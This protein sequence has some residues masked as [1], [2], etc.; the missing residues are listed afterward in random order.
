MPPGEL[1]GR[2]LREF[3]ADDDDTPQTWSG[4]AHGASTCQEVR[5]VGGD[6]AVRNAIV[7][8]RPIGPDDESGQGVL[9]GT[10]TAGGILLMVAD[11]TDLRKAE[12]A[13]REKESVLRS[14]Y[15]SSVMAMG[16]IEQTEDDTRFIS[17]N[18]LT[19]RFFGL[20]PGKLEGMTAS[21][22]RSTC[23]DD[24]GLDRAVP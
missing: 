1:V 24:V 4:V 15:E 6:G 20:A 14:F 17:A 5:L 7:T 21:K 19:D 8:A 16:V 9:S 11:V 22:L 12:V 10:G 2:P 18:A 13:L 3:L 23:R